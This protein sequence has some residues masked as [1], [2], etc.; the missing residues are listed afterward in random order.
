MPPL[1]NPM[2]DQEGA[3]LS[4]ARVGLDIIV[5]E[6][7]RPSRY[8]RGRLMMATTRFELVTKGL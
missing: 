4:C 7:K 3:V 2:V 8:W 6:T 1:G 5:G